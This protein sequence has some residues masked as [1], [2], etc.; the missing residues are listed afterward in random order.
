MTGKDLSNVTT[1]SDPSS[2][3][4]AVARPPRNV[5]DPARTGLVIFD[6]LECY[7]QGIEEADAIEPAVRLVA[8]CRELGVP[9]FYARA[10]HRADGADFTRTLTDTDRGFRP[11]DAASPQ[12][13]RPPHG[14]GSPG[15]QVIAELAPRPGDYDIPKHRF[16]AFYG[17]RL[18]LSLRARGIDT[19]LVIGGST[20]VGV[21]STVYAARDMDFHVVVVRDCCT[22]FAEQREYFMDRVFPRM[23]RVATL[24]RVSDMFAASDNHAPTEPGIYG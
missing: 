15:L 7:R 18:E 12:P 8:R 3:T 13:D 19:I 24:E 1:Y 16:S 10:D 23:C 9:I 4:A 20:H 22:G 6:M 17:T 14:S 11:W 21:A 5:L 2:H